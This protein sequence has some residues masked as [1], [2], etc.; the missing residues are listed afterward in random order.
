MKYDGLYFSKPNETLRSIL[1]TH[2]CCNIDIIYAPQA[3]KLL[4]GVGDYV[5]FDLVGL[6]YWKRNFMHLV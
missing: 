6:G 3:D 5:L 4:L 2:L 1:S